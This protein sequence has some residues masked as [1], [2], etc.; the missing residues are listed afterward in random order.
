MVE[1]GNWY[2]NRNRRK[3][4]TDLE[5]ARDGEASEQAEE[6]TSEGSC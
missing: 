1:W 2:C 6:L 3:L 4:R 5:Q